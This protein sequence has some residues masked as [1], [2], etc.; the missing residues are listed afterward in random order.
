METVNTIFQFLL[1]QANGW[2]V[3]IYVLAAS[4]IC[5]VALGFLQFRYFIDAWRYAFAPAKAAESSDKVIHMTPLQAFIS[6]LSAN[7]GNGSIVGMATAVYA[8]GPGAAFWVLAIGFFLMVIRFAEVFLSTYYASTA[9]TRAG[10][11]G[12]MLYLR[13]VPLG[14]GLAAIYGVMTLVFGL[15][16]GNGVQANSISSCLQTNWGVPIEISA[17]ALLIFVFYIIS[18]G[19]ARVARVSER[20]VPLK[21]ATFFISAFI[22][23]IYHY[24]AIIPALQ[25]IWQSAFQPAAIAGGAA[26]ATVFAVRQA[27]QK[28]IIRSIFATETGLG[29][30]GILYGATGSEEPIKDGIMSML[31]TFISTL[32]C[33]IVALCILVS[34]VLPVGLEE[35]LYGMPLTIATFNTVFGQFG[36]WIVTFLSI[37]FGAGVLVSYAYI[38]REVWLFLTKGRFTMVFN[39]IYCAVSFIAALVSAE[40]VWNTG[41]IIVAIMLFINLYGI[42][43]LIPIIRRSLAIFEGTR[44]RTND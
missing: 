30:A 4:L 6:T 2:P 24:K 20:L 25:L 43:Y 27:M 11:G 36:G 7:L 41:D 42:V 1:E 9:S 40:V 38:T 21:V 8:G 19:A 22:I 35:R 26:G 16:V 5:T 15:L 34:D 18:G 31:S 13:N 3:I 32:V 23:L 17:V 37:S 29:T 33:F 39:V 12:P 10:L 14:Y 44:E 28:G